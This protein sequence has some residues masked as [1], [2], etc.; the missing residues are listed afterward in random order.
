MHKLESQENAPLPKVEFEL[1]SVEDQAGIIKR[2]Y[3]RDNARW[4]PMFTHAFPQLKDA[5]DKSQ[6]DEDKFIACKTI[7][8]TK[9]N[10]Q[11]EKLLE[12]QVMLENEWGLI[13]NLFLSALSQ[14]FETEWPIDKKIMKA[15]VSI[16]PIFPRDLNTYSFYV[17]IRDAER[18]IETTAHEI[19]HFLWFK[20]WKEVFP[21]IPREQYEIPHLVWRLSEIMDPIIL[22]CHPEIKKLIKPK[23]WGYTSFEKIKIGDIGMT[24]HFKNLYL[25]SVD[26]GKSF[27]DI[28]RI[29][30]AEAQKYEKEISVF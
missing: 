30:Y 14:H 21:E 19:V 5:I 8:E 26:E 13:N 15:K 18:E 10:T 25:K 1:A 2:F 22:Q 3:E 17:G 24:E 12:A 11:R 20:K 9:I 7:V 29:C 4:I 28:L 16:L 27:D 6:S 23:G